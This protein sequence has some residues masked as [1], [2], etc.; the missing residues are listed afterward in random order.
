[1]FPTLNV[2]GIFGTIPDTP[3]KVQEGLCVATRHLGRN[4]SLLSEIASTIQVAKVPHVIEKDISFVCGIR[5][6]LEDGKCNS[7][8]YSQGERVHGIDGISPCLSA[9]M[10]GTANGSVLIVEGIDNMKEL[11]M[12]PIKRPPMVE[13][14]KKK[15]RAMPEVNLVDMGIPFGNNQPTSKLKDILETNVEPKYYLRKEIV[16]K[17]VKESGFEERLVSLKTPYNRDEPKMGSDISYCLDAT[18]VK[19][20]NT[21]MKSNRQLVGEGNPEIVTLN[22]PKHS[23]NKI[24]SEDGISPTLTTMGGRNRQ[25]SI[26]EDQTTVAYSKS[27]RDTHVDHRGKVDGE[28]NTI[29]TGDG[30]GNQSTQNFVVQYNRKDE[31]GKELEVSHTLNSSDWRGINRNQ[32][33]SAVL[34][35][36]TPNAKYK[37]EN[38]YS[39]EGIGPCLQAHQG[40]TAGKSALTTN[41]S[42]PY[43]IRKLT[44]R[45]C[46]KLQGYPDVLHKIT[47]SLCSDQVKNYVNVVSK[48]PRLQ[49][50]VENVEL[51]EL[52]KLVHVAKNSLPHHHKTTF[53]VVENANT[54]ATQVEFRRQSSELNG[55][56][57]SVVASI[58]LDHQKLGE[59]FVT[60][61][62][63]ASITE[64]QITLHGKVGYRHSGMCISPNLNG[65]SLQDILEKEMGSHVLSVVGNATVRGKATSIISN[66]LNTHFLYSSL[67]TL[68]YYAEAAMNGFTQQETMPKSISLTMEYTSGHTVYGRR[69]NGEVYE[70][71]NTQRYRQCGNGVSSPVPAYILSKLIPKDE[72]IE[73]FSLFSGIGGTELDLDKEQFKTVALCEWDKFAS[74]VLRYHH[75]ETINFGDVTKVLERRAEVPRCNMVAGGFPC[76]AWSSAGLRQGFDDARGRGDMVFRMFKIIQELKPKYVLCENVKGLMTFDGGNAFIE[77][78]KSLS[79]LGYEFDFE[80]LNS[81]NFGLAQNRERMFLFGR[82]KT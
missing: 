82:L 44:P 50:F 23:N 69:E 3:I 6:R 39:D 61:S 14:L 75:P 10:G 49:R 20:T 77:I 1:M 74:D 8:N 70:M 31:V 26:Y 22:E 53:H 16:E 60:E 11:S 19:G 34:E 68:Y 56:V 47:F 33:Q 35:C 58:L 5:K 72:Q 64:E 37:S 79:E 13:K 45:E 63:V 71:T 29:S 32:D 78:C 27:T 36:L 65:E 7:R 30:G 15:L 52:R 18:Y 51:Q 12:K 25:P 57:D 40:G 24:Y 4:G 2:R 46:E 67:A 80:I 59:N 43:R 9:Q 41:V 73:L 21:T 76:Q 81:K 28:A 62:V 17:I 66:H 38:V 48:N 42:E 54:E 55:T